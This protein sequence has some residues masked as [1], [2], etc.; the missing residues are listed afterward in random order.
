LLVADGAG[1]IGQVEVGEGA[2]GTIK[3]L[4]AKGAVIHQYDVAQIRVIFQKAHLE[5]VHSKRQKKR[6]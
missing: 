3:I 6:Q 4:D 1:M 5:P 2:G